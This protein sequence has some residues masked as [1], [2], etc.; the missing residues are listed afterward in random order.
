[1][2]PSSAV[3]LHLSTEWQYW[4][5]SETEADFPCSSTVTLGHALAHKYLQPSWKDKWREY[6]IL[7]GT[8]MKKQN[9]LLSL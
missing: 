6:E 4:V 5:I 3:V 1:M 7:P 8:H 9:N 2:R